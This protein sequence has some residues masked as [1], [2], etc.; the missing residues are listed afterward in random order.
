MEADSLF[1]ILI[2]Y[3]GVEIIIEW[4]SGLKIVGKTDTFFE[5]DNGLD[6]DDPKYAEYY[7]TAFQVNH[8]LSQ[9]SS[10]EGSVYNWLK[11]QKSSLVEISLYDDPPSAVFLTDG[12]SVWKR[13]SQK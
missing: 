11:Q 2:E 6:D 3:E 4:N 7:A 10:N 12:Q 9:P 13:D 1:K 8:I 5:T